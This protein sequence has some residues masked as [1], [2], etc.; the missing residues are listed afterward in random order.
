MQLP[1]YI[2]PAGLQSDV[3]THMTARYLAAAF[4][5]A[6]TKC[7]TTVQLS[8][9]DVSILLLPDPNA[10]SGNKVLIMEPYLEGGLVQQLNHVGKSGRLF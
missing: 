9:H 1:A 10:P 8:Y 4:N 7:G 5:V 6:L 3:C 2:V